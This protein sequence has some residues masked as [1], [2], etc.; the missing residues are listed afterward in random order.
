MYLLENN[1]KNKVE[2]VLKMVVFYTHTRL[3]T[4]KENK[5]LI[6]NFAYKLFV[7]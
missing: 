2:K 1:I 4:A 7:F 3:N 6:G 5:Q